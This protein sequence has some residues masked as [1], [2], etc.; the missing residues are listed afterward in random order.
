M[1]FIRSSLFILK[2]IIAR[3]STPFIFAGV[4][5]GMTAWFKYLQKFFSGDFGSEL[6]FD[7]G[8]RCELQSLKL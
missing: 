7:N 3:N 4:C 2:C 5:A 8:G 1:L 6:V